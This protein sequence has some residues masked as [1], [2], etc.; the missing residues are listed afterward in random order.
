MPPR[1]RVARQTYPRAAARPRHRVVVVAYDRVALFE[2][3]IAT[4]VFGLA[5]PELG[6]PWYEFAVCSLERRPLQATG[7]IEIRTRG[8]LGLLERA[9]TIIVPGWRDPTEAPPR[10]LIAALTRAHARGTRLVSICS[11]VFVLAATGLLDGKRATTHWRYTD[12][13]RR[14][15][16]SIRVEPDVLHVDDGRVFTSAGSAA[17]ID[18]CLHLVR[19]DHGAEI[20]NQVARRLVVPPHRD[21]GQAQFIDRPIPREPG[22]A[23]A[24]ALEWAL[25]RLDEPIGVNELAAA[26]ALSPRTLLRRFQEGLG[27]T[28]HAW[29]TLQRVLAAQRLLEKAGASIEEVAASVGF[30]T[31]QTLRLH[32]RRIMR[33]SPTGYRKQFFTRSIPPAGGA[34]A[35]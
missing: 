35:D 3:A 29:L 23:L 17:G 11:G 12:Q 10:R 22:R 15:Y 26:A 14:A 20:A 18:L 28:P 4:E 33:T 21:G 25:S 7:S 1:S 31:A 6:V 8:G 27:T 32:F 5:R 19:L 30:R 34:R 9:D 16:P 13:L 2:L 24:K